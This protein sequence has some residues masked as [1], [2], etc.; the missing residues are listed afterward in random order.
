MTDLAIN[1]KPKYGT[2]Q[3]REK[4]SALSSTKPSL[5][6]DKYANQIKPIVGNDTKGI[7]KR[8]ANSISLD[9]A[10]PTK[11]TESQRHGVAQKVRELIGGDKTIK[12]QADIEAYNSKPLFFNNSYTH[13][14]VSTVSEVGTAV[15]GAVA[16]GVGLI[17]G[18]HKLPKN[19]LSATIVPKRY[20]TYRDNLD[21]KWFNEVGELDW[22]K[23]AGFMQEPSR[24]ILKKG[25]VIDRY[26]SKTG[27][28][29]RGKFLSPEGT[30]YPS[31]A[32]PY[33]ETKM[34]YTKYEV[35]KE[36]EV[37]S[38]KSTPWFGEKGGGTQ[39]Q[40]DMSVRDLIKSKV[41]RE[42]K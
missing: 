22:P 42:V 24:E 28:K 7:F 14:D 13:G 10:Y 17:K 27:A 20:P 39:Y 16:G 12:N 8:F 33:D 30:P 6:F 32:L 34:K 26:S 11:L 41:L 25:K 15:I 3:F 4:A 18:L 2:G 1:N 31:R 29:D 36:F 21:A 38:G 37:S 40:T 5:S 23:N 9:S 35:I 19:T